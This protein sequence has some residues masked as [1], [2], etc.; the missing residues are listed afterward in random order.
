MEYL[1]AAFHEPFGSNLFQRVF[2]FGAP[3]PPP[4]EGLF[5]TAENGDFLTTESDVFYTTNE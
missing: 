5:L 3:V 1:W 2:D 4:L